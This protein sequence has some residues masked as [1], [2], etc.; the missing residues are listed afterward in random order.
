MKNKLVLLA[1]VGITSI[2]IFPTQEIPKAENLLIDFMKMASTISE[3][4]MPREIIQAKIE[5]FINQ[6]GNLNENIYSSS[7]I[8]KLK[9]SQIQFRAKDFEKLNKFTLLGICV[10]CDL[11]EFADILFKYGA[12]ASFDDVINVL[13]THQDSDSILY[14]LKSMNYY[15]AILPIALGASVIYCAYKC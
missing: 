13:R 2:E 6:N 10:L 1:I 4:D 14:L 12:K 9:L 5:E 3:K 8:E 15:K 11:D 7:F